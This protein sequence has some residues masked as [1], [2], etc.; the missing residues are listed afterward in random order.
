VIKRDRIPVTA[1]AKTLIDLATLLSPARLE[2]AVNEADRLDLIDPDSLR[3]AAE[4][5][6]NMPGLVSLRRILDSRTFQPTDSALERR[7]LSLLRRSGLPRPHTGSHVNGYKVD[8]FWPEL[9]LVV[10]IDGLRYHRTPGQQARDRERDQ[11]HARAG[12]TTLRF[13]NA[14]V[15]DDPEAVIATVKDV[16][17]RLSSSRGRYPRP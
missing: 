17:A 14:Q 16:A 12:L 11:A 10:E 9:D 15:R 5:R 8:F 3:E 13:T 2:A 7:L 4:E 6:R 1:P